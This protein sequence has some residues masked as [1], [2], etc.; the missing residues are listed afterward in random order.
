MRARTTR[1]LL[2]ACAAA[3]PLLAA[4]AAAQELARTV[5]AWPYDSGARANPA[6]RTEVLV[7]ETVHVQGA[8]WMRVFFGPV[9]LA[10]DPAAGDA[11][12][13][14]VTSH[15]D[16][17]VQELDARH[18]REWRGSSAYFNGDTVQVE[19]VA[20]PASGPSRLRLRAVSAGLPGVETICGADDRVPSSDPRVARSFPA[21][22][23]AWLVD[24]CNHC[25]I[26]AGHCAGGSLQVVQF[27]VPL[28][29]AAGN[30][31][32]PPPEDQYAVDATSIQS[33]NGG[34]GDDWGYF[35]TFPNPNTGLHAFEAQGGF[36][37]LAADVPPSPG[38]VRITGHGTDSQPPEHN[39]VQQTDTG[40]FLVA[41]G[42]QLR[43]R[44]DLAGGNSGSPLIDED[45]GVAI[46][47][48]T[49]AACT[50]AGGYNIATGVNQ[51]GWRA[52]LA[53]P[54]GVCGPAASTGPQAYCVGKF[55]SLGCFPYLTWEGEA[56]ASDP[57]PFRLV[58][59]DLIRDEWGFLVYG[60]SGRASLP[61]HNGTLCVKG[62]FTRVL[63]PKN[64]GS[65]GSGFCP[66]EIRR[67]FNKTIQA[68]ADPLLTAGQL[69]QAQLVYRDPGVDAFGDGLTDAVEFVVCP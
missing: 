47:V 68:G 56:S 37:E 3:L 18:L 48:A 26:T 5:V 31:Q 4:P 15:R 28:S 36:F 19:L 42:A 12:F 35:G 8:P 27:D 33:S 67:N 51:A 43:F 29:D 60:T 49:H 23:T 65:P 21:L 2:A 16:G 39:R 57:A 1:S 46:G 17:A 66:G 64:S 25:M 62:P 63:P 34:V 54:R 44:V 55:N 61:F 40:P 22:C 7:S 58:A 69:V 14:R 20:P 6:A 38:T 32:H 30:V 45:T 24:D 52:A 11:A 41:V 53:D 9:E 50:S 13:V 59:N 10:G